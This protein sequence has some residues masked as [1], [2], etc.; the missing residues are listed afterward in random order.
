M[1]RQSSTTRSCG[2]TWESEPN[3]VPASASPVSGAPAA[4]SPRSTA[5]KLTP[6]ANRQQRRHRGHRSWAYVDETFDSAEVQHVRGA[7]MFLG[8]IHP[9]RCSSIPQTQ[10][11]LVD[12]APSGFSGRGCVN[13]FLQRVCSWLT[14]N[15]F[16]TP[17]APRGQNPHTAVRRQA[18]ALGKG[19]FVLPRRRRPAW[20]E[21]GYATF[22]K[23]FL[24]T[25]RCR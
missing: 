15:A 1:R 21:S 22:R 24:T 13:G 23:W 8:A 5:G 19:D 14:E 17:R 2:P 20:T 3:E 16:D 25:P 12:D 10:P 6:I 9:H 7:E 4:A 11:H 18:D